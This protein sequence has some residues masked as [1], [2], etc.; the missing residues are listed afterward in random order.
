MNEV[1]KKTEEQVVK[2]QKAKEDK[3]LDSKPKE[4]HYHKN[5]K[6]FNKFKKE[7]ETKK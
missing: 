2:N 6:R 7:N 5:K 3:S 4:K 1:E